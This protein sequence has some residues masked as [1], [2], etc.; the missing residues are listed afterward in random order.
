MTSSAAPTMPGAVLQEGSWIEFGADL[1]AAIA[2]IIDDTVHFISVSNW[3][4]VGW[5]FGTYLTHPVHIYGYL[6]YKLMSALRAV[7][8][9][10]SVPRFSPQRPF[11]A[12]FDDSARFDSKILIVLRLCFKFD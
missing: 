5:P 12:R 3:L 1:S 2:S 4:V 8:N 7:S 10:K 6:G 11:D 9:R